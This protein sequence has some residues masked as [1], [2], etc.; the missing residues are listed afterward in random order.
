VIAPGD[1][2]GTLTIDGANVVIGNA[3]RLAIELS[4][5]SSD[6]LRINRGSP[7]GVQGGD[8]LLSSASASL[9]VT[10][11]GPLTATS[12][13]IATYAGTLTG[14]FNHVTPGYSVTYDTAQRRLVLNVLPRADFDTDGDVDGADFLAW[15]QGLG[16][17]SGA[18]KAQGDANNDGAVDGADF[19]SWQR[20]VGTMAPTSHSVPEPAAVAMTAIAALVFFAN[21]RKAVGRVA[22]RRLRSKPISVPNQEKPC[23]LIWT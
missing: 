11:L 3:G 21:R 16:T 1:S 10:A 2:I 17:A 14:T 12:Y 9:D 15:Q 13:V 4:G 20:Q 7:S 22:W 18:T 8:L 23:K 5:S 6:L 19:L